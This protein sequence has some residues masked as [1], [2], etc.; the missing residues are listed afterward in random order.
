MNLKEAFRYQNYLDNL[1]KSAQYSLAD[2]SH[3]LKSTRN[4]LRSKANP[5]AVDEVETVE[6]EP[7]FPNDDVIRFMEWLVQER[8][9]LCAA[10][11]FT[12]STLGID[13]DA[14]VE[15][16]KFRQRTASSIRNMLQNKASKKIVQG[17]GHKFNNEGV[18]SPYYYDIEVVRAEAFDR[19]HSREVMRALLAEAD[20]VSAAVDEAMVIAT[21]NY[22]P[23]Y[24]VNESF[25]DV[26]E[27]F[28]AS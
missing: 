14:A 21:V 7:F 5:D 15:T 9:R 6:V 4:H 24:D 10:I 28:A 1:M 12:K 20:K 11:N 16:N 19:A 23:V 22:D 3:A 27:A 25:E 2:S 17:T 26:M 13:I 18:Q 8:E